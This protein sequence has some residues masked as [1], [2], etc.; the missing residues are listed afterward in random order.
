MCE[1][2]S[3][4]LM[5]TK[6]F[7]VFLSLAYSLMAKGN[8]KYYFKHLNTESGLSQ[9]TVLSILQDR[10]GFMWF[11]TKDGLN[12][13]D[14]TSFKVFKSDSRNVNSIGNNTIWSLLQIP[15]SDIWVGT[16]KGIYVYHPETESFSPFRQKTADNKYIC[17][18]VR[19]M[20]MDA[21]GNIYIASND[22]FRYSI[23]TGKLETMIS[24]DQDPNSSILSKVWSINIDQDKQIWISIYHGGIKKYNPIEYNIRSYTKDTQGN[25]FGS[26]LISKTVDINNNF[27]L[28]GAFNENLR[29]L[30]KSTGD[31]YPYHLSNDKQEKLFVR[32]LAVFSDGNCWIGTET[33]LYIHDMKKQTTVHLTHNINDKYSLSDNAVYSMYEDREGGIW[34]GTYFGGV[35]YFPRP[36][37]YFTK[38]Y[39]TGNDNTLSGERVSGICED[40]DG[41]VWIGTEDA[42]LN[43]LNVNTQHFEH[44]MPAYMTGSSEKSINYHN[45]HD[46]VIDDS[47][48]WV[49]TYSHGI[50]ILDLKRNI[51]EQFQKEYGNGLNN[52][53]IFALFKD[54]TGKIWVGTSTGAFLFDRTTKK[55]NLLNSI[56]IRF[57]SDI[58]E[59]A[60]GLIWFSTY[61]N[62][63]YSYNPRT[64]EYKNYQHN[65]N[66]TTSICYYK[67][68]CMHLDARERLWFA[69]ESNGICLFDP[70]NETFKQFG[71]KDGFSSNVIYMILHDDN[72]NLWLSSNSGLICFNPDTK[73][74]RLF[75][76][77]NGLP[78]NQ[79]N[80]KSGY[81]DKCGNLYFGS[82]KGLVRFQPANFTLNRHIPP[83]IINSFQLLGSDS[84]PQN[85]S[86]MGKK[87]VLAHDQS[88][89]CIGF[90]ALSFVAPETNRYAYKMDGLEQVW[91][92]LPAAQK[93][94]YSNLP[95]G[96][97][98]FHVKATNNDGIWNEI[99][100]SIEII[101]R[102]PFW[103]TKLAYLLYALLGGGLI[104]LLLH[105]YIQR[106]KH[107][108]EQ[109]QLLFEKEK[110]K[111]MYGFKIGFFTNIAHEIRTPLTLIKGPLEQILRSDIRHDDL[112]SNLAIMKKNT[113]RLLSLINQLLDFRKVE[114]NNFNLIFMNTNMNRL[115]NDIGI[116]FKPLSQQR[117][118]SFEMRLPD[119][120]VFADVDPEA[121]TKII[122]N[123]F[124]NAIKH[125]RS[126]ILVELAMEQKSCQIKVRNDGARIPFDVRE[127]IFEPF[128]QIV[129][130]GESERKSGSGIGLSLARSLADMHH[131]KIF[132]DTGDSQFTSF[133]VQLP[134][135]Q[136][137][138]FVA[139][140]TPE[141]EHSPDI[142]SNPVI[143]KANYNI[144]L[145]DDNDEL[146]D[147]LVDILRVCYTVFIAKDGSEAMMILEKEVINLI[148]TDIMMP[149]VDGLDLCSKVKND[150]SF[151]HIPVIILTAKVDIQDRITG[152]KSGADAYI[153]KPFSTDYL[154]SQISNL[155]D[156]RRK[157][158]AAFVN[159]PYMRTDNMVSTK[160]DEQF[161]KKL[162]DIINQ[163]IADFD[164]NVEVLSREM[165]MSRSNLLRKVKNLTDHTPNDLIRIIRLKRAA[166]LLAN[167]D[168]KINEVC[169]LVG[170][171]ST[172]YFSKMFQKQFG[173]LPKDFMKKKKRTFS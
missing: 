75:T 97:Y 131:G 83:V 4:L 38:F 151:S 57:I 34:I 40:W 82:L 62:G 6:I 117:G 102:P 136:E 147:F 106:L 31:I 10:A 124:T 121:T 138:V 158:Q 13:Y 55:F 54:S 84:L 77:S 88:S 59:D 24:I 51:W 80:Y 41:N 14:G 74:I 91:N 129:D 47:L 86:I 5:K 103:K 8:D 30:N 126:R 172:S 113:D 133:V 29:M 108:S 35:N 114:S 98:V 25:Y 141:L 160:L 109:R 112:K 3:L 152:L 15:N 134:L 64:Q 68:T 61:D 139:Q 107:D 22:L 50:N 73:Q 49:A 143:E 127:R 149:H 78:A 1:F 7:I 39:P 71:V 89:F 145:V 27:L 163:H 122:S 21:H 110:E 36:F 19:D 37:N 58:I 28:I 164:F 104:F 65:P 130:E 155:L 125:A 111:E 171:S 23:H 123:L 76:Q 81:K 146:L 17:D 144:L 135:R 33:G 92:H 12:R 170:F 142:P 118:L 2:L 60:Y 52:N 66:D 120:S 32:D 173:L 95:P 116:R 48:L 26:A 44:F 20:K 94:T 166:E 167:D 69:S 161:L 85:R 11:G 157:V 45:I 156:N 63:V 67:I 150:V 159:F 119:E 132:L 153:E 154:L 162:S 100:D 87:I 18:I 101:I 96:K 72:D 53:D 70:T 16:D 99:G 46:I 90:A 140:Q 165:C 168:C 128:F 79:F 115:L 43:K 148:I 137:Q 105:Y 42:G 56:G 93:I 169:Y 9:N